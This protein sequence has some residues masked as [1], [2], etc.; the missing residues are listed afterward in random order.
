[1]GDFQVDASVLQ[2][3]ILRG[4]M[5]DDPSRKELQEAKHPFKQYYNQ[6]RL[7]ENDSQ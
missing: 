1:M 7:K 4:L 6:Y 3:E 2:Q 5:Q